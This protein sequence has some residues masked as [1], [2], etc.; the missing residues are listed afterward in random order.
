MELYTKKDLLQHAAR[1]GSEISEDTLNKWDADGLLPPHT[2]KPG[3]KGRGRPKVYFPDPAPDAILWLT[4]HRRFIEGVDAT[5]FWMWVEGFDYIDVDINLFVR[6]RV[7]GFWNSLREL[8]PSLPAIELA[9]ETTE[10]AWWGI[11]DEVDANITTPLLADGRLLE[12][13]LPLAAIGQAFLG[14]IPGEWLATIPILIGAAYDDSCRPPVDYLEGKGWQSLVNRAGL[15]Y[16]STAANLIQV[17]QLAV[18]GGIQGDLLRAMWDTDPTTFSRPPQGLDRKLLSLMKSL[19]QPG[20][21]S[22]IQS[23]GYEP[24]S[25]IVRYAAMQPIAEWLA[26]AILQL[27]QKFGGNIATNGES[28]GQLRAIG[29]G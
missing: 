22:G 8:V 18:R 13:D 12:D 4:T 23:Y 21:G 14:I 28:L 5:K 20:M 11:R 24:L 26:S 17:Y 9:A 29:D 19:Q 7:A 25:L 1:K 6:D 2:Q 15:L 10:E 3:P 16:M 27:L